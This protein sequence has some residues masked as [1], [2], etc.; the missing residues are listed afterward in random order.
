M[1][2]IIEAIRNLPLLR[3]SLDL[4]EDDGDDS[5]QAGEISSLKIHANR[6]DFLPVKCGVTYAL[7]VTVERLARRAT[8]STACTAILIRNHFL[9]TPHV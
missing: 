1:L 8:V 7:N 2:Q 3:V 6:R 4:V 9:T 5:P